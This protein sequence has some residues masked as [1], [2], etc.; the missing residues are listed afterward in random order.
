MRMSRHKVKTYQAIESGYIIVDEL[1]GRTFLH[2][3]ATNRKKAWERFCGP[4]GGVRKT[5]QQRGMRCVFISVSFEYQIPGKE[6]E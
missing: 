2:T 4:I 1:E 3:F 6:A 5:W